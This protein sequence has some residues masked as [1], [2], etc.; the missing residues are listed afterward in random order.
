MFLQALR[1]RRRAPKELYYI[2][3][4]SEKRKVNPGPGEKGKDG[5]M[6]RRR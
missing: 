6:E 1:P 3:G 4:I 5:I 2:T